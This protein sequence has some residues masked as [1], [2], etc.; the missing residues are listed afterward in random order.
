M[1]L[2]SNNLIQEVLQSHHIP[3]QAKFLIK[4]LYTDFNTSVVTSNCNT[5]FITVGRGVLQGDCLSPLLFDMYFNTFLQHIK[6]EQYRQCGF[7]DTNSKHTSS[8]NTIH[9]FQFAVDV[10]VISNQEA[11]KQI[12]LN[13][14]SVWCN[15]ANMT[16]RVDNCV[17]FGIRKSMTKS[18]QFHPKLLINRDL[19]QCVK[20]GASFRYLGRH[21]DF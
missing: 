15:W 21:F 8:L 17:T 19:V 5:P 6:A 2:G 3:D 20:T 9:W 1:L 7:L 14:F 18:V 12:P 11:E 13:R 4:S 16:I 10:A